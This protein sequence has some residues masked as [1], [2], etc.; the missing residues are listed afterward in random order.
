MSDFDYG[1]MKL[2]DVER[3]K[4]LGKKIRS[5][6]SGKVVDVVLIGKMLVEV[7]A[8]FDSYEGNKNG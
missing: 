5:M 4:E 6:H 7:K 3:I 1:D 8:I 2:K